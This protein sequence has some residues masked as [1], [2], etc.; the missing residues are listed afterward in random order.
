MAKKPYMINQFDPNRPKYQNTVD[1][2]MQI[3]RNWNN[4][5]KIRPLV[6]EQRRINQQAQ[7]QAGS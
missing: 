6:E 4:I 5:E 3:L 7:Q 1:L 2:S